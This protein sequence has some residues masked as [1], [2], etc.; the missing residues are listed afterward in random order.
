MARLAFAPGSFEL[1]TAFYSL[2]H[3]PRSEHSEVLAS[4]FRWLRP[5]GYLVVTMGVDEWE[6]TESNWNGAPTMF[7][8]HWGS[9]RNRQLISDAGFQTRH[10]EEV[11]AEENGRRV[12]FLW[13]VAQRPAGRGSRDDGGLRRLPGGVREPRVR[14]EPAQMPFRARACRTKRCDRTRTESRWLCCVESEL[15]AQDRAAVRVSF[16]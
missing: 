6:G 9:A 11:F 3:V 4:A 16:R 1:I 5:G 2:I 8:S 13:I 15:G 7:W 14:D 12:G 10:A